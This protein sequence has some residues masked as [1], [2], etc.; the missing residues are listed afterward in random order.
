MLM[1]SLATTSVAVLLIAPLAAN[2]EKPSPVEV[3]NA[4]P[5]PV[6]GTVSSDDTTVELFDDF[7]NL[8]KPDYR[9]NPQVGPI[10]VKDYK[11]IRVVLRLSACGPCGAVPPRAFIRTVGSRTAEARTI[12]KVII[13]NPDGDIG[14]WASRSYDTVGTQLVIS[15]Q[16]DPGSNTT[17]RAIIFGRRN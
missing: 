1:K 13:D 4:D 3:V 6:V 14:Q 9:D 8:T 16:T 15:F 7:L 17:V 5:I 12:D 11:S 10:D 2:A